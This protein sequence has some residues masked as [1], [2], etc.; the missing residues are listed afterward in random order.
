M[1]ESSGRESHNPPAFSGKDTES[2]EPSLYVC[3]EGE[4][5]QS[6]YVVECVIESRMVGLKLREGSHQWILGQLRIRRCKGISVC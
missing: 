4:S 6:E 2:E 5:S 3:F 1:S